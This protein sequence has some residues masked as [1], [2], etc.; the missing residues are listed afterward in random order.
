MTPEH[1][2]KLIA[3]L[4]KELGEQVEYCKR[5]GCGHS[6]IAHFTEPLNN[7]K[8]IDWPDI[9]TRCIRCDCKD[10]LR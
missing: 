5:E 1:E 3:Y 7:T 4:E 8:A 9:P 6:D 2:S 10:F